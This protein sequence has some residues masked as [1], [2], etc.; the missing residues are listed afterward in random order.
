MKCAETM[1]LVAQALKDRGATSYKAEMHVTAM[2]IAIEKVVKAG[3]EVSRE[4]MTAVIH[5]LYNHS[6]WRQKFEKAG[7]FAKAGDRTGDI[8]AAMQEEG[9]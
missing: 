7:V 2:A 3:M 1:M 5:A 4:N 6:A 9:V 8:L